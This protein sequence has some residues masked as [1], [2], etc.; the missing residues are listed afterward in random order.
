MRKPT[1]RHP[2]RPDHGRQGHHPLPPFAF[3]RHTPA[4][5]RTGSRIA[6]HLHPPQPRG[7]PNPDRREP[8]TEC[9]LATTT[10]SASVPHALATVAAP[11]RTGPTRTSNIAWGCTTWQNDTGVT[12]AETR[13]PTRFPSEPSRTPTVPRPADGGSAEGSIHRLDRDARARGRAVTG[14]VG[15]GTA[16]PPHASHAG[17][18]QRHARAPHTDARGAMERYC[19][20]A[21]G[22]LILNRPTP[23]LAR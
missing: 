8:N 5:P 12:P 6:Q 11:A 17:R 19:I 10:T 7:E 4:T 21:S 1:E 13:T 23:R 18:A 2:A 16:L 9:R 20:V 15:S 14:G 3:P 22:D